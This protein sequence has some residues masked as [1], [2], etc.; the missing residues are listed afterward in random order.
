MATSSSQLAFSPR[1]AGI[2]RDYNYRYNTT[3][4]F[5]QKIRDQENYNKKVIYA[6]EKD[7]EIE[8]LK[9]TCF[10]LNKS[11]VLV[12]Q[13]QVEIQSLKKRLSDQENMNQ[14]QGEEIEQYEE[15]RLSYEKTRKAQEKVISDYEKR[16]L[17]QEEVIGEYERI[18]IAHKRDNKAL[19]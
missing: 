7:I 13:L 17:Q 10:T 12:T 15:N 18:R 11:A 16:R 19:K 1:G 6:K 9:T 3:F 8:R 2:G 5:Q 4:S 14:L